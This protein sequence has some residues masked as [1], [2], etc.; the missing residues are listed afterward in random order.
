MSARA[1]ARARTHAPVRP[2]SVS[3]AFFAAFSFTTSIEAG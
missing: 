1:T 2:L 3:A